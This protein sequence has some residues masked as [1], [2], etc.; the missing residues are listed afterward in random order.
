MRFTSIALTVFAVLVSGCASRPQEAVRILDTALTE[1]S[2]RVGVAIAQLPQP[3]TSFPG[4]SCLLC[5]AAAS[6][7]NS[8]LTTHTRT[9]STDEFKEVKKLLADRVA[10][11]GASVEVID[12][13]INLAD[14]PDNDAKGPNIARKD[15]TG[16][17]NKLN[18][19]KLLL[20]VVTELGMLRTYSAYVPTSP[21]RAYL[22]GQGF[23]I[24]LKSNVYEW[25]QPLAR[26]Q[27]AEGEWHEPPKFPGLTNAYFQLLE[28]SKDELLKSLEP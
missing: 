22:R 14:L 21:P 13:D 7:A 12:T 18:V 11:R 26:F 16:L 10:K 19:D 6:A 17:R 15:F 28:S 23:I 27:G 3:D 24:D 2:T 25:F 20:V 8:A 4:A 1:R 5:I 9:L